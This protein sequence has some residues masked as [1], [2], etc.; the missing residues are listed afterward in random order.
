MISPAFGIRYTHSI[1]YTER[2][3]FEICFT[4][5]EWANKSKWT[6]Y[7]WHSIWSIA[8]DCSTLNELNKTKCITL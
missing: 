8:N 5:D 2:S 4:I 7:D 3:S 6:F 1:E